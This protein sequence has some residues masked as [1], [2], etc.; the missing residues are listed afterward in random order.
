MN[1]IINLNVK[2]KAIIVSM[3]LLVQFLFSQVLQYYTVDPNVVYHGDEDTKLNIEVYTTGQDIARVYLFD[4]FE[5]DLYD[6]GTHGDRIAGDGIYTISELEHKTGDRGTYFGG[7]Q[8]IY[9]TTGFDVKVEKSDGSEETEYIRFAWVAADQQFETTKLADNIYA[10][11]YALFIV[12]EGGESF[13]I[14]DWP[15]GNIRC[16]KENFEVTKKLYSVLPDIFDFIIIMPAHQ[17]FK[18]DTYTENVPYFVRAKNEVQNIGIDIFDNTAN[19]GS[20]GKLMGTIFHSWGYGAI[21]DHE[22]GHAWC[23]DIGESLGLCKVEDA[24]GWISNHWN[25]QSD[26]GGQMTAF[27]P[28]PNADYGAGHLL[29]NGDG[30]WRI[31]REPTDNMPYSMLD[32]YAMGLIPKEEVPPIHILH[33]IDQTNYLAVTAAK[34]DTITI[35]DIIAAEGGERIPSFNDSPKEFNVAFVVVKHKE[36]TAPEF[37]FYSNISKFFASEEAGY[38]SITPFYSATGGRA[39]LDPTLHIE[40]LATELETPIVDFSLSQNYP[41]PF[42]PITTIKYYLS[43]Q[44]NIDITIFDERGREVS[45]LISTVQPSGNYTLVWDGRNKNGVQLSNGIYFYRL[46]AGNFIQTRKMVLLK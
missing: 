38:G 27:F 36:F 33:D 20:A 44:A 13:D 42:N 14:T 21:L 35:D 40:G 39:R 5:A 37:A 43:E 6:D 26:I 32:L 24:Y 9:N 31:E 15:L 2:R 4:P 34:V 45:N 1:D 17:I 23:A 46:R 41:N 25:Y 7:R 29:D 30:T 11:Q 16:G 28:N 3:T 10:T 22:I 18:P 8:Y 19:F 12:D